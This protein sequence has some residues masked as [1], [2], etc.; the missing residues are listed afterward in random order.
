MA[1]LEEQMFT[2]FISISSGCLAA[3]CFDVYKALVRFFHIRR[4]ALSVG[5]ILFWIVLSGLIFAFLLFSNDGEMRG[6][7]LVGLAAGVG[8]YLRI[9]GEHSPRVITRVLEITHQIILFMARVLAWSW[10]GITVPF[11]LVYWVAAWPL[12]MAFTLTNKLRYFMAGNSKKVFVPFSF[13]KERL[14]RK[15]K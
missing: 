2:F 10:I 8:I 15:K 1:P 7:M 11:K 9:L 6:F 3:F 5:D 12:K 14:G 4:F 13:I